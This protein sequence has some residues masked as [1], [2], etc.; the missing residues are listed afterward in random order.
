MEKQ[1]RRWQLAS[2]AVLGVLAVLITSIVASA[3]AESSDAAGVAEDP[4]PQER[5]AVL[6]AVELQKD[7][8]A[9][10]DGT[11]YAA[12]YTPDGELVVF[13][14]THLQGRQEIAD[15]MQFAFD[16]FL[17][18]TTLFDGPVES[19]RK[20]ASQTIVMVS[21]GCVLQPG[22]TTCAADALSRQTSVFV[23]HQGD[24]LFTSFHNSRITA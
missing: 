11:A 4:S 8:W 19:L 20:V 3:G 24:W 13:D 22:E 5:Q 18:N 17:P 10:G 16:N 2:V 21:S 15:F 7:A 9:D 14:G 12:T 23:K 6:A 1:R